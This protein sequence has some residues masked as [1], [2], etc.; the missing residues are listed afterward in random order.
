MKNEGDAKLIWQKTCEEYLKPEL[1][2]L[3]FQTWFEPIEPFLDEDKR[4]ILYVPNDLTKEFVSKYIPLIEN[5]LRLATSNSFELLVEEKSAQQLEAMKQTADP[6]FLN[7][8]LD[9]A[10]ASTFKPTPARESK[11]NPAYTFDSFVVGPSNRF[12]HAACVAVASMHGSKNYNPLFLY[13]GS[14][15][16]KTHLMQA[17]GNHVNAEYKDKRVRYVQSEQFVNEFIQ[18]IANKKYDTFRQK[19]RQV[20]LLLIDDIQFIEGKEQMQEEFFHTFNSLLEAGRNIVLTCDKPPQSLTTL[21]DRLRTRISSGLTIDINP[22]DYETRMA[23]LAR[24]AQTHGLIITDDV[25]DYIATNVTSNIRELEGAF[26]TLYAYSLLGN[27]INLENARH[28]LKDIVAPAA[29]RQLD[30]NYIMNV[31]ANYFDVTVADLK[32]KKR[33]QLITDARHVAMY[34]C[35]NLIDMTY[36]NI[37]A[38]FG[39]RNHATV[40]HAC[41]KIEKDMLEKPEI[42]RAIKEIRLRLDA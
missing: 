3:A 15:L 20:D 8:S 6:G 40:I 37:G 21:E 5:A 16:G 35:Y 18:V 7:V 38:D 41:N 24:L 10:K 22:P 12:A 13:G 1:S 9:S 42:D 39:E 34:L 29:R 31:C 14:G 25:L 2:A 17:I 33:N 30:S 27:P 4:F 19:Y 11:L 36:T 28:S 32:S 26:K 23:I